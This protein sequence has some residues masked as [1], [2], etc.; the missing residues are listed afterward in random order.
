MCIRDRACT[1][2][3]LVEL[4]EDTLYRMN[5]GYGSGMGGMLGTC[6]AVTAAVLLTSLRTSEGPGGKSRP[7]TARLA[8]M[9]TAEFQ[10]KNGSLV[11]RELKGIG[12]GHKMR[13]CD[14]CIE[15]AAKLVEKY[16]FDKEE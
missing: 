13:S 11:C 5:E 8:R 9:I 3:D 10:E 4:D 1:Y 15:D 16:L 14:G 12:G 2:C 6:G 7:Q